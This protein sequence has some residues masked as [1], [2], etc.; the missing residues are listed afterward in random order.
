MTEE[1]SCQQKKLY[2]N[3]ENKWGVWIL[4]SPEFQTFDECIKWDENH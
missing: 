2:H 4:V 3:R 1:E